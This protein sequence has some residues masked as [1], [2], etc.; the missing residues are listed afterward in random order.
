MSI[1]LSGFDVVKGAAILLVVFGHVW[2]GLETAG[3][4]PDQAL[5]ARVDAATY[6]FH[7][8]VFFLL[9]GLFFSDK[10]PPLVFLRSRM[11][12][13]IWPMVLWAWL[14]AGLRFLAHAPL[15]G[16]LLTPF[17]VLRAP[18]PSQGIY[19]FLLALFTLSLLAY[20]A[21]Q[22]PRHLRFW[23]IGA[24]IFTALMGWINVAP[25][26]FLWPSVIYLPPFFA[27]IVLAMIV[28][29]TALLGKGFALPGALLF[30]LGQAILA[31]H[32]PEEGHLWAALAT[33]TA[34]LGFVLIFA[35]LRGPAPVV[36]RLE[37]LGQ[38][39][40]PIYLSHIIFTGA[41]RMIL[42]RFGFDG[43]A[44]HLVLGTAAGVIGPLLLVHA[45]QR[46]GLSR[47]LGFGPMAQRAGPAG[48]RPV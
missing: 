32:L 14:D 23:V 36:A 40:M 17:E 37:R 1:R 4:M 35:N 16:K 42:T 11:M 38:L 41:A 34:T 39:T 21:A 43:L 45:A 12:L 27:G 31:F 46:F 5:F 9:S 22:I 13:L 25:F 19:W 33:A 10:L 26:N 29:R 24:M 18:F 47:W 15:K 30:L 7:M 6:L 3:L 20:A 48:A 8:P 44:L 2:R 28:P